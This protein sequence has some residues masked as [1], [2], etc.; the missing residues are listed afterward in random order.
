MWDSVVILLAI[1]AGG[2]VL[3]FVVGY[4]YGRKHKLLGLMDRDEYVKQFDHY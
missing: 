2:I 3:G 1:Q 4:W